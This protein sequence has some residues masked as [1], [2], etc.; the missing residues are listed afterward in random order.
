MGIIRL[1]FITSLNS[2]D[3]LDIVLKIFLYIKDSDLGSRSCNP[4]CAMNGCLHICDISSILF[5][6]II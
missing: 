4:F 1:M 6:Y 5:Q 3:S 2:S